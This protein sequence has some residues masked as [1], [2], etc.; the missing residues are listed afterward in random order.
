M[1][2]NDIFVGVEWVIAKFWQAGRYAGTQKDLSLRFRDFYCWI[3]IIRDCP[4]R[5]FVDSISWI[6]SVGGSHV[7]CQF[8]SHINEKFPCATARPSSGLTSYNDL[9][10]VDRWSIPGWMV[11]QFIRLASGF[12]YQCPSWIGV[13]LVRFTFY[14]K[15]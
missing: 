5:G 3:F 8:T 10:R 12:L 15:R 7:G 6:A 11:N 2:R 4:K 1:G 9:S 13:F 14:S